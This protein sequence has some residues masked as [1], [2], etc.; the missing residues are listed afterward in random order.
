MIRAILFLAYAV[1]SSLTFGQTNKVERTDGSAPVAS[2]AA[3]TLT[4]SVFPSQ[5]CTISGGPFNCSHTCSYVEA[6]VFV[7]EPNNPAKPAK[8]FGHVQPSLTDIH[9]NCAQPIA[10]HLQTFTRTDISEAVGVHTFQSFVLQSNGART[11]GFSVAQVEWTAPPPPPAGTVSFLADAIGWGPSDGF[12]NKTAYPLITGDWNGDG[13]TDWARVHYYGIRFFTS[14]GSAFPQYVDIGDWGV[15]QGFTDNNVYPLIAGDWNGDG[16]TDWA[17]VHYWG[18]RFFT[19]DG[20]GGFQ[21]YADLSDWGPSGG[22]S[23]AD[24]YPIITGD[25]NGDGK[26]DWA[27]VHY[28]GIRFFISNAAGFTQYA[29]MPGWGPGG[30]LSNG[31]TYPLIAGDW[32]GDGKTDW[33]RVT[34]SGL[35]FFISNGSGF[36]E[37]PLIADF[38]PGAGYPDAATNP[39]ITG[40]WTGDARTGWGRLRPGGDMY[41]CSLTSFGPGTPSLACG[42]P[43]QVS[44]QPPTAATEN[45][46]PMVVGDWN[47]D[48][49]TDWARV[50]DNGIQFWIAT[51]GNQFIKY[52]RQDG[53]GPNG[54]LTDGNVYPFFAGDWDGDHK[55]DFLRGKSDRQSF[56]VVR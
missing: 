46:Y 11:N 30:G 15:Q 49:L 31:S 2:G 32:N 18:F 13:K 24:A 53:L 29:E 34:P 14:S 27:R 16:K 28:Y 48:G 1:S 10:G 54:G 55:V 40:R 50:D 39:I 52:A 51:G 47:G 45:R 42:S 3:V 6:D 5:T 35:K 21:Q 19:S 37:G 17:R 4:V 43:V 36:D 9:G 7:D 41:F 56:Y 8:A 38:Y 26:T 12:T 22:F 20:V 23:S 25:W 33:A 44:S